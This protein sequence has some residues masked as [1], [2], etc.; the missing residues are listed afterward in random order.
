MNV[1][2]F[3][4]PEPYRRLPI[5]NRAALWALII[6]LYWSWVFTAGAL[7]VWFEIAAGDPEESYSQLSDVISAFCGGL[8]GVVSGPF[9]TL[10][11]VSLMRRGSL[12]AP[13]A[14][15]VGL[16]VAWAWILLR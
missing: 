10:W 13:I 15:A 12:V 8:I 5:T 4:R 14:V 11:A 3:S 1:F 2:G 16:I 7:G 9:V 6:V